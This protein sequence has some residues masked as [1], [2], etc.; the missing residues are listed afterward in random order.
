MA[1]KTRQRVGV[2]TM[3]HQRVVALWHYSCPECG[4]TDEETG[5]HA[6]TDAIYCEICIETNGQ[7][8][9][10]RRWPIDP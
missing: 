3:T 1:T 10:L 2:P 7:H 9:R 8:V 6:T 4:I 5:H